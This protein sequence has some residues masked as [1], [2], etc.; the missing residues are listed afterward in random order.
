MHLIIDQIFYH[1]KDENAFQCQE[2]LQ[3]NWI[4]ESKTFPGEDFSLDEKKD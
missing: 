3:G 2:T 4:R 1:A